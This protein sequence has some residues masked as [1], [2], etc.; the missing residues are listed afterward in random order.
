MLG[1]PEHGNI[2]ERF[3]VGTVAFA[4]GCLVEDSYD[5]PFMSFVA[6]P[7]SSGVAGITGQLRVHNPTVIVNDSGGTETVTAASAP[8]SSESESSAGIAVL[9]G[10]GCT[11]AL[12]Q[13]GS[14]NA[15]L[16]P[17]G[18]GDGGLDLSLEVL[19]NAR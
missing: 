10:K 13:A 18:V 15:S 19:C 4:R 8:A 1:D 14:F 9:G 3:L 5:R 12:S 7:N 16:E 6:G 17:W 11:A 2:V